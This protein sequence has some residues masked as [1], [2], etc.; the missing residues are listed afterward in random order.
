M[1]RSTESN[2]CTPTTA[3]TTLACW[4]STANLA[5]FLASKSSFSRRHCDLK[6]ERTRTHADNVSSMSIEI[7]AIETL[8]LVETGYAIVVEGLRK[9]YGK[10]VAVDSYDFSVWSLWMFGCIRRI[11]IG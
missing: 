6:H 8:D 10:S 2:A 11:V 9:S 1:P 3:P 5:S 7:P 4:R